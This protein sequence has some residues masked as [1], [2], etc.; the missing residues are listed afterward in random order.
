[1]MSTINCNTT[2]NQNCSANFQICL[3]V[4]TSLTL[5]KGTKFVI[6]AE[7][8]YFIGVKKKNQQH[9][10]I[11]DIII[12]INQKQEEQWMREQL[13]RIRFDQNSNKFKIKDMG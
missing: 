8:A 1:M 7:K 11:N 13:V 5:Q 4:I 9:V 6:N 2:P 12:N 3:N 10:Q